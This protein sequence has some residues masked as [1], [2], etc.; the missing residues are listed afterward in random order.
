LSRPLPGALLAAVLLIGGSAAHAEPVLQLAV[1]EN[2]QTRLWHLPVQGEAEPRP[3]A[4]AAALRAPLGSLWKLFVH[5]WLQAN[6]ADEPAYECRGQHRDEVYCCEPGQRIEREQALLKS[7]GLYYEPKRLGISAS[8][9]QRYWQQRGAPEWLQQLA[10]MQPASEVPVS[11]LLRELERL[12]AR[13]AIQTQ[14]AAAL[15]LQPE[16]VFD[17]LGAQLR[18]KTWSWHRGSEDVRI[19]GFAGW[20]SDGRA[21]WAEGRG[22]SRSVLQRHAAGIARQ[23]PAAR[24]MQ[25]GEC[26]EVRMFARY[27]LARI[28]AL[29]GTAAPRGALQGRYRL[30][31]ASGNTL[32]VESRGELLLQNEA[33][34]PTIHAR[35][36]REDYVARVL[37]R[38]GHTENS[39]AA[40][41]LAIAIRSYLAQQAETGSGC[42]R[43]EDSSSRQRVAPRPA[44]ASAQAAAAF[45]E[46][47][48]LVGM[49]VQYH[50]DQA[51]PGQLSW[52]QLL[53]DARAGASVQT[54]LRQTWPQAELVAWGRAQ[55][56]CEVLS[57]AQAWL[58]AQRPRWR[59][60]LDAE[61]GHEERP[62]VQVCRLQAGRPFADRARQRVHVRGLRS[63]QDQLDLTHEYLH[64]AFE[65]H[66]HG[67]DE[68]FIEA[69]AR[70]LVLGQ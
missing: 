59:R 32:N 13:E 5:A 37:Q 51:A 35:L 20:R 62:E 50:S 34:V 44:S 9:W 25:A 22:T 17:A 4:E 12:P 7:C 21:L 65:A 18:V 52:A 55:T 23:L 61:F 54:L 47:L 33:G 3:Q 56:Q 66:P 11:E 6:E 1:R 43:I 2:G 63:Q 45:S 15:L 38:E 27:P 53:R 31:F 16:P 8:D 67:Q 42:L 69:W 70:R 60:L 49:P 36:S 26:V 41:V 14:L 39:T 46:G 57:E 40:R 28:E 30:H 48:V 64:L 58:A 24:T 10:A 68:D 29:D 19:G